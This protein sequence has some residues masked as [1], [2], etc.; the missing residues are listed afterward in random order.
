MEVLM[1]SRSPVGIA[2]CAASLDLVAGLAF[3]LTLAP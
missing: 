1:A 2:A 3:P